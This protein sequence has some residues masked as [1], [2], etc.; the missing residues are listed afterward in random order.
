MQKTFKIK[1]ALAVPLALDALLFLIVLLI[2]IFGKG[3]SLERWVLSIGVIPL[4][5]ISLE[6]FI[7]QVGADDAGLKI[8]KLLRTKELLWSDITHVGAL[9]LK[10]KVY[11]VLTTTKGFHVVSN[12]YN[13]F[14]GLIREVLNRIERDK[15]ED[16][17]AGLVEHPIERVSDIVLSW[18]AAVVI[19]GIIFI[20][21]LG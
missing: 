15:I 8:K 17:V 7:R 1:K 10:K 4:V 20:K 18:V 13:D 16:N 11:L 19:A 21:L 6:M 2:T 5:L 9:I 14:T 12:A 3:S